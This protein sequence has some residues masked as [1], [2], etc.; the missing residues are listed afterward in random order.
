MKSPPVRYA[1][2]I[3]EK[4]NPIHRIARMV[5][6]DA[7]LNTS[8][9]PKRFWCGLPQARLPILWPSDWS[10][11][12]DSRLANDFGIQS[13]PRSHSVRVCLNWAFPNLRSVRHCNF[14]SC[15]SAGVILQYRPTRPETIAP[16]N[17]F[18]V[19]LRSGPIGNAR[20]TD[21]G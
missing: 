9:C 12:R 6:T 11:I 4:S 13:A 8:A 5:R 17:R 3:I 21:P 1:R 18:A 10:D 14:S 16:A 2:P 20:L 7:E 19:G 15:P